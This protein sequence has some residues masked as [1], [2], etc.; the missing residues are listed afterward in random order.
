M[1]TVHGWAF[2]DADELMCRELNP[3]GTYQSSHYRL[4]RQYITNWSIAIDGGA[5]CGTWSRLMA[6]D[7]ELVV[8]V[9]PSPDTFEALAINMARFDLVN[10]ELR[11][12]A[13]GAARG[14]VSMI[15][16]GR[17]AE[18]ANTGARH[19]TEGESIVC[20][21]IDDWQLDRLGF[22]KLDVEGSELAAL[23]GAA[24]TIARCLPIILFEDKRL[25]NRYYQ[26]PIDAPQRF[27]RSLGYKHLARVSCDEIWGPT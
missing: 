18:Q 12:V 14:S 9:E 23:Q 6:A 13:L 24:L 3:D 7:F 5:H 1:K 17:G 10:V 15:L 20:E 25:W 11:N 27:L 16:D 2:P 26:Q 22:L 4:C 19:V 21:T 8:A